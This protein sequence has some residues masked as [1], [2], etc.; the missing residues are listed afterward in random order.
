MSCACAVT[1]AVVLAAPIAAKRTYAAVDA[2]ES[3]VNSNNRALTP[4]ARSAHV[5]ANSIGLLIMFNL[6]L[7]LLC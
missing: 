5:S 4:R 6:W 3:N 2:T 7:G 1:L